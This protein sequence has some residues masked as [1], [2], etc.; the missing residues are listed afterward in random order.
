MP[1]LTRE[2]IEAAIAGFEQQKTKIDDQIAE[3]RAM[4][5]GSAPTGKTTAEV[6]KPQRTMSAAG[7]RAIAEA[8][9]KRWAA[10][11]GASVPAAKK[12]SARKTKRKLSPQGKQP[13]SQP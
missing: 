9:R 7:R 6:G 2:I 1:T 3:L 12:Q 11:R 10:T 4:L 13:L 5:P 8:Q